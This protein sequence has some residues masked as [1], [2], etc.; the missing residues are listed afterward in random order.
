MKL[1][2]SI[3][4]LAASL[5]F[6]LAGNAFAQE[7]PEEVIVSG[8]RSISVQE[9]DTSITLLDATTIDQA[10][11]S[12]FEELIQIVPNMNLSGDGSRARY[13]Q[14]RGI[15]EREQYEGAPNPSVGLIIDDIDGDHQCKALQ[16]HHEPA[17]HH[18]VHAFLWSSGHSH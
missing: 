2:R 15:G 13:I 6:S 9:L 12:H 10:S 17:I 8:F 18:E 14:L 3:R 4:L 5:P 7:G 1:V 16:R 11:V